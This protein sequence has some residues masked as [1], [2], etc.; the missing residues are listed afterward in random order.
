MQ[1]SF[2][3]LPTALLFVAAISFT[4]CDSGVSAVP[5]AK[6]FSVTAN[7][8]VLTHDL[9]F[10]NDHEQSLVQVEM[11]ITVY[12]ERERVE[13]KRYWS[14]WRPGEQKRVNIPA[15]GGPVQRVTISGDAGYGDDKPF[16]VRIEAGWVWTDKPAD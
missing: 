4:G 8:G 7:W 9:L 2:P 16:S 15:G 3:T 11:T 12:K 10:T 14:A 13:F 1:R 5:A 6:K